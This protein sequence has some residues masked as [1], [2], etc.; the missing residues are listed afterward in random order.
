[1]DERQRLLPLDGTIIDLKRLTR[2]QGTS[3]PRGFKGGSLP[4]IL[5]PIMIRH[6]ILS[7]REAQ[8]GL[9]KAQHSENGKRKRSAPYCGSVGIVRFFPPDQPLWPL[10]PFVILQRDVEKPFFGAMV[11]VCFRDKNSCC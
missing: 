9:L 2:T 11:F 1:M 10:I 5:L 4:Q 8:S 3:Y 7:L 6:A